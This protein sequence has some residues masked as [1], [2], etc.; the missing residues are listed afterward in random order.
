MTDAAEKFESF[1]DRAGIKE[2]AKIEKHLAACDSE[3]TAS[4]GLLWRR[5]AGMLGDLAPLGIQSVGNNAW[6]FFVADGKYR[7]QVFA[8]E[9]SF[10]GM[11]QVYLPDMLSEAVKKKI[12]AKTGVSHT[13]AVEGSETRLKI[14]SL[15]VAEASNAPAHYQHM[16]GWNRKAIRL[17]LST[18]KPDKKL[19]DAVHSLAMLAAKGWAAPDT[20]TK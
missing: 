11:L 7:M 16:L 4:H 18:T 3:T 10:D 1:L 9:D 2:R 6:K 8:L 15:G 13:F 14:D 20:A 12:L 19:G 5:I 17:T